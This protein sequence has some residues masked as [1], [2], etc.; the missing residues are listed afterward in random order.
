[1]LEHHTKS[2]TP[3]PDVAA[4]SFNQAFQAP[5]NYRVTSDLWA[6][7]PSS[8]QHQ[9]IR[10]LCRCQEPPDGLAGLTNPDGNE[11]FASMAIASSRTVRRNGKGHRLF[12][13][14]E[15]NQLCSLL[16][17]PCVRGANADAD[18]NAVRCKQFLI[19]NQ[20]RFSLPLHHYY[21]SK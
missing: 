11:T 19:F 2:Y 17:Q 16:A 9:R 13:D 20:P 18:A 8:F 10:L 7:L 1:M 12:T 14:P 3:V 4:A 6:V 21:N 5:S 15:S